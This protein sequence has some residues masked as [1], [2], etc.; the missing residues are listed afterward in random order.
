[1]HQGTAC[2][3][4][5]H[6]FSNWKWT[7][8]AEHA[9]NAAVHF[10]KKGHR[11][12]FACALPPHPVEDSLIQ[13][14]EQAGLE[15]QKGLYLNKHLTM[16][17]SA[18]DMYRLRSY[19]QS[20]RFQLIHTHL[21]NDHLLTAGARLLGACRVPII[22]T[23][24]DGPEF[25]PTLRNRLLLKYCTDSLITV[26]EAARQAIS[27]VFR[28]PARR[29][30]NICP[31]V[32]CEKFH[33]G[34]DGSPVRKQYGISADD[35]VVGIVARVQKHRRFEVLIRALSQ[36]IE[37]IPRLKVL[38]IG[39]GTHMEEI[40]VKPVHELGLE[41]NI[42][43]TGYHLE[44]YP[45][46]LAALDVKIFLVPGSDGS[47]RAVREA[48]AMGKPIIAANRGMLPE[49]VQD[50]V[51]G[52]VVEDTPDNLA[53]AIIRLVTDVP[54][55]RKM[56]EASRQRICSEFSLNGQMDKVESVYRQTLHS[57]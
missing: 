17:R 3:N 16:L 43:M 36:V 47:C 31:G 4:L 26:S 42:I 45:A 21:P 49:L 18:G 8:P 14:A 12:V 39:R 40:A 23:V 52:F 1:M 10:M 55:R 27:N 11:V 33:P 48:M 25:R 44:D 5:L 6:I 29:I 46:L 57:A 54:L 30:W 38:L 35:P 24:Y 9:L 7:G 2:M 28:I 32:D 20:N 22:R 37:Q 56:G 41:K 19:M 53:R 13:R 34:I 51:S 50:G 15:I